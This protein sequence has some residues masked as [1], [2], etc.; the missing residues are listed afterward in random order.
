MI[1]IKLKL[2]AG[3]IGAR[4]DFIAGWLGTLPNYINNQWHIDPATGQSNGFMRETKYLD[5]GQHN[6]LQLLTDQGFKLC[7]SAEYTWA[8]ACHG[9]ALDPTVIIPI[10]ESGLLEI[11]QIECGPQ[12]TNEIFWNFLVKTFLTPDL[13]AGN[14]AHRTPWLIDQ[15]IT[16][17]ATDAMRIAKL[18]ELA[19]NPKWIYSVKNHIP[20]TKINYDVIISDQGSEELGKLLSVSVPHNCHLLWKNMLPLSFAP[21]SMQVW[22]HTW[23]KHDLVDSYVELPEQHS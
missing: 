22:G 5:H 11:V 15:R 4:M 1:P 19:S 20:T 16:E 14:L 21:E 2:I 3:P 18:Q 9:F 17:P 13:H 23:S 12:H 6:L 7:A 10:V 8:G